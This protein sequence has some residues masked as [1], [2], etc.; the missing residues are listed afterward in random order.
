MDKAEKYYR[1][2]LTLDPESPDRLNSLAYF[3]ID[4]DRNL[5]EGIRLVDNALNLRPDSYNYLHT[6]GWG[7]FKQ[8]NYEE[9]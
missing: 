9:A 7:L 6:K 4:N 8:A 1:Q 5:N 2:A 3:L